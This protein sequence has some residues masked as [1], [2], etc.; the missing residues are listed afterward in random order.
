M[1]LISFKFLYAQFQYTFGNLILNVG[2]RSL[3]HG[4][5]GLI[6]AQL[7]ANIDTIFSRAHRYIDYSSN[8][9]LF[10]GSIW[11]L[12]GM[13]ILGP[14]DFSMIGFRESRILARC[15]PAHSSH[16]SVRM[17]LSCKNVMGCCIFM[18]SGTRSAFR[19]MLFLRA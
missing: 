12:P 1:F 8:K 7:K 3:I 11:G 6:L 16:V 4:I 18:T 14:G 13:N 19:P 9:A 15:T 10:N 2:L 5:R 17:S